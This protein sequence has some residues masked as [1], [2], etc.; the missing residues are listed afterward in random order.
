LA[1]LIETL[2]SWDKSLFQFLNGFH[3][4]FGDDLML[5]ITEKYTWVPLYAILLYALIKFG[6]TKPLFILLGIALLIT[7]ADQTA[8]GILKPWIER[9][10][11]CYEPS[12]EGL[13]NLVGG[14]G[15]SYGF[16]SS[17]AANTMAVAC[18]CFLQLR[19]K[20]AWA[21]VLFIWAALVGYSR[22][23]LGVHYPGDVLTGM[24]IGLASGTLIH[25]ILS[26]P[27]IQKNQYG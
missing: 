12:I 9:L 25:K 17:H 16:A 10:R 20:Y 5:I 26:L 11:P 3:S 15:G 7:I 24:L 14:C 1:R 4:P 22:I 13:V 27:Q 6:K 8:S 23:Y 19:Q 2:D 21:W 18:F